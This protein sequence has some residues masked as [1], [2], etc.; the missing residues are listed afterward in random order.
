M[1]L[2]DNK[3]IIFE[4]Y[5]WYYY[6]PDIIINKKYVYYMTFINQYFSNEIIKKTLNLYEEHARKIGEYYYIDQKLNYFYLIVV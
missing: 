1:K 5:L 2:D 3:V 6:H 4:N